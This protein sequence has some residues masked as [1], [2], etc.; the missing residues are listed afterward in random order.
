M[1][2]AAGDN[3]NLR[4]LT[5]VAR[6]GR[7]G[8]LALTVSTEVARIALLVSSTL[9]GRDNAGRGFSTMAR[10]WGGNISLLGQRRAEPG[11]SCSIGQ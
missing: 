4:P 5:W 3:F 1:R 8:E 10:R 2:R 6:T 11:D 7:P 9:S